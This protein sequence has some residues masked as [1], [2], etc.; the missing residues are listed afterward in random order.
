MT[1][2]FATYAEFLETIPDAALVVER[3]GRIVL[4][5]SQSV[6]LFG[7]GDGQL[8]GIPIHKLLPKSHQKYHAAHVD[9][10]FSSPRVRT[11]TSRTDLNGRHASGADIPVEIM[12]K[13]IAFNGVTHALC[14]IRDVTEQRRVE[15]ALKRAIEREQE[16]ARTDFLTG[17]ANARL[18]HDLVQREIDRFRRFRRP[19]TIVYLD[20]DNF[21]TINDQ[22]GH[23]VGDQLLCAVVDNAGSRL[24]KIDCIARLGGDEFAFL[25]TEADSGT[26][27][28]VMDA[29]HQVLLAEMAKNHWPVT[30]SIGVLTCHD[31]PENAA[32]LIEMADEL[33]YKVKN[34]GKN[35]V[36]YAVFDPDLNAD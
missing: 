2:E 15:A 11:M 6:Q 9:G 19:F 30:F 34:N 33:M 28:K 16:L 4:A 18:F 29:V 22:F 17:A 21:K 36:S 13:P 8:T 26:A 24:R 25:L 5:N 35:A 14:V 20:L 31:T 10:Y 32:V 7:Y 1:F 3:G 23:G 27:H 12:L